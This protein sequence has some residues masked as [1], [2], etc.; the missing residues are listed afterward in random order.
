MKATAE[1]IDLLTCALDVKLQVVRK[2]RTASFRQRGD[3]SLMLHEAEFGLARC[4][5]SSTLHT[6]S[7]STRFV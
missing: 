4:I 7:M 1:E 3:A 2:V 5:L 6:I